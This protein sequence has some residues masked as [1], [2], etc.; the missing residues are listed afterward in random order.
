MSELCGFIAGNLVEAGVAADP[1]GLAVTPD[2]DLSVLGLDSFTIMELVL[3]LER[4]F[5]VSLALELL[6]PENTRTVR[7]L[8]TCL[9]AA[10]SP[11]LQ[12]E[13]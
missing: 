3:F 7:A 8:T 13:R 10:C 12:P 4:R 9:L 5:K 1:A 6:T 11:V 2:T